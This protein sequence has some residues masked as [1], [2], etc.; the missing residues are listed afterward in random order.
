MDQ[1]DL[2]EILRRHAAPASDF[3]GLDPEHARFDDA[4]YRILPVPYE[5]TTSYGGG[6]REG[7]GAILEA[8]RQIELYDAELDSEPYTAG[9]CTLPTVEPQDAGPEAMAESLE[10]IARSLREPGRV[11][12]A[13]G[14]EHSIT[15]ALARPYME[16]PSVWILCVDAHA[17]LR[18]SYRGSSFSHACAM[19]SMAETGRTVQVG[20]RSLSAEERTWAAG[21]DLTILY[22]WELDDEGRW[23]DRVFDALGPKV[24]FSLDVDGLDP[25]IMPATGTPEP[26]GLSWGQL[27]A[28]LD[29]LGAEREVVAA[30]VVELAPIPGIHAPSFLAARAVYRLI[31]AIE[32]GRKEG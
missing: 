31:G 28:L 30:D 16:E 27:T 1:K 29:R 14:G 8:S 12:I 25:G 23:L 15:P 6:A 4:R 13:L 7:P 21:R 17:D 24:Y 3:L 11:V 19:R 32:A 22:A 9:I 18:A 5:A 20:I 26:G 2:P 10:E